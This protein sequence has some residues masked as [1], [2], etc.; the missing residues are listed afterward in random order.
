MIRYDAG[1]TALR[2][3]FPATY[4]EPLALAAAVE[5]VGGTLAPAGADYLLT[6]AG[7]PAQT[8][9]QA[10]GIFATLQGVPLQD[11]I[12]LAAYRPAADPLVS[13]VILLTGNDHFAARFLIPSIIANSRDF[14]IEILVVFNGLWLD[15]ALF[16][17]V[18]ILESDFGWV[19]QGYNAGAAAARGRY[20]AFFHDDC[21]LLTP[22]W[23]PRLLAALEAGAQAAAA[24]ISRFDNKVATAKS[25][26]LLI[27][28]ARFAELGGYDTAYF[29]G[30][31]DTDFSYKIWSAGGHIAAV[32]DISL[33]FAGMSTVI[34]YSQ[35]PDLFRYLFGIHLLPPATIRQFQQFYM[36][37]VQSQREM[38]LLLDRD[39]L[40]FTQKYG[41]Y[42][43]ATGVAQADKM[44]RLL[45]RLGPVQADPFVQQSRNP[46]FIQGFYRQLV[47]NR[48]E[49]SLTQVKA[50]YL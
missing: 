21:L 13:C 26:P 4:H 14:P 24:A 29:V 42:L 11:T 45:A 50:A 37:R 33:H 1:E 6:L 9:S 39:I 25:V 44:A 5:K 30:Y 47:L 36:A 34:L 40:Y 28:R 27:T 15:R 16:G 32:A 10:A 43:L 35:Q 23:I 49:R 7:P 8:G 46:Q 41:D 17:A 19:S 38:K 18:P 3:R 2:L 31:E 12:D 48:R 22:D 20:I